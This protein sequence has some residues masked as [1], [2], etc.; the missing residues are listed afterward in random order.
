MLWELRG[1][2]V[3]RLLS[4]LIG[5]NN[6]D[7]HS[8]IGLQP[9][10]LLTLFAKCRSLVACDSVVSVTICRHFSGGSWKTCI[11]TT[12][13]FPSKCS[14]I[15]GMWQH[16]TYDNKISWHVLCFC[17]IVHTFLVMHSVWALLGYTFIGKHHREVNCVFLDNLHHSRYR[18]LW[19]LFQVT[20]EPVTKQ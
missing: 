15:P 19:I 13:S 7:M 10:S 11:F 5:I 17:L 14:S 3:K 16:W 4:Y 1:E 18:F 12:R 8:I 20:D 2:R 9:A 6:F